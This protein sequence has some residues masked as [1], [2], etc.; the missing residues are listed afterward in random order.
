M[1]DVYLIK[2]WTLFS[3]VKSR[4]RF[5]FPT[6]SHQLSHIHQ[7]HRNYSWAYIWVLEFPAFI[8][9]VTSLVCSTITKKKFTK[10]IVGTFWSLD[11]PGEK[12][13]TFVHMIHPKRTIMLHLKDEEYKRLILELPKGKDNIEEEASIIT[14]LITYHQE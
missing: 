11:T 3:L 2:I 12:P 14:R 4:F 13:K 6:S 9:Q 7:R 10:Y 5:L 8:T 1:L